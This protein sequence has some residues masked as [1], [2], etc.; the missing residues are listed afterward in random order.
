MKY[1][2]VLIIGFLV[3][4]CKE[5]AKGRAIRLVDEWDGKVIVYPDSMRFVALG[6]DT[7]YVPKSD[8]TIITY[9]DSM[10]CTSCKLQLSQW[11]NFMAQLDSIKETSVAILFFLHSKDKKEVTYVMKQSNFIY[12]VCI[13]ETDAFNRLNKFPNDA[14]FQTF[15]LDK[16][17]KVIAIGNP[18]Y[19]PQVKELY[20]KILSGDKSPK[21]EEKTQTTVACNTSIID[22]GTF[23]WLQGQK[24]N[25][26][27]KNTGGNPL[28]IT[29]VITSCGCTSVEYN[30]E[31]VRSGGIVG[32]EVNY[33]ADHPEHFNKTITV[34]C[35][36]EVS[37][38]ELKI[39]GTA[40]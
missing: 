31:P 13:D 10:G 3:V 15:L 36:A 27:L 38:I 20:L 35:N 5:S 18:V 40:E 14:A 26:A 39:K 6:V 25:F 30:K 16:S 33:K 28:V 17:S 23:S 11:K 29:D 9:V 1:L 2:I 8:Y 32:L 37:P 22:M 4:S 24:A 7:N 19:N 21:K 12:P 34:H